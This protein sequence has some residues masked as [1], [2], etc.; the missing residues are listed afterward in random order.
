MRILHLLDVSA[1]TIAGYASRSRAIVNGQRAIG[2]DPI[3]LTSVRHKNRNGAALEEIDGIRHYRTLKPA[4]P[5]RQPLA[6]MYWL[7]QRILEVARSERAEVIHAHSPILTGIPAWMAARQLGLGCVYEIRSLWEDAAVE[8]GAMSERSL[9]YRLSRGAETFLTR[10]V[11]A[12]V[13]ICEGLRRDV[14]ARGL[15]AERLR[16]VPNGVD[17]ARFTP[18]PPDDATRARLGLQGRTV[19]GYIGTFFGF[20]GVVDLVEAL[21]RL[22]KQ[23]R[24]DLAGLIVGTGTTYEACR[25]IAQ[26]YGL[27][28]RIIHPGHVA[29]EEVERLYSVMDVLAY[30]RRSL[31]VTELVTPLKPLEAMA[32]EKAVIGSDVGGISELIEDGVTGLLHRPGDIGDLAAKI[33][34][35]AGNPTLRR[36]LGRQAR[37]WVVAERDWTRIIRQYLPV[38]EAATRARRPTPRRDYAG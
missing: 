20:E 25:G 14:G 21:A 3:V 37:E 15:P 36:T 29:A 13:C 16:V 8:K 4:F 31:R 10:R 1:P 2:L 23:G 17:V 28:D 33:E 11:D 32:M 26:R 30:P 18:R 7:R 5:K 12:V 24:N 6:E 35:L 34:M 19:V 22:I 27:A 9:R 38:Y